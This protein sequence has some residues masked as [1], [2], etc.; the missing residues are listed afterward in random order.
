MEIVNKTWQNLEKIKAEKPL[1]HHITNMVV[2]NE[3]AN[4][5]LCLGALPV[6]AHAQEEVCEMVEHAGAL[7]LNIGTLT[8]DLVKSMVLAGCHANQLG[9]P[10]IL[11][12][13][14]VGATKLR[15]K[16][17]QTL[18]GQVKLA[19]IRGNAAEIA[20]LAG[21]EAEIKGVEAINTDA[22]LTEVCV[23]LAQDL[24]TSVAVTGPIDLVTDGKRFAEIS[25]G[26]P[27]LSTVTGTGC[28]ATSVIGAFLAVEKD[29]FLAAAGGLLTFGIAGQLAAQ[30]A[31]LKPGSF[32]VAL[33]DALANLTENDLRK[34]A[35][36]T[37]R[38]VAA[39][40]EQVV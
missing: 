4:A 36:I 15:T 31:P 2:M 5:T 12:P 32:H 37:E 8:S 17:A 24:K 40:K 18:M 11:D 20:V 25:N 16:S 33:Y 26:H 23:A 27:L 14:G 10:V 19:V 39:A 3:T 38:Q 1:I 29:P 22:N 30:A 35:K 6:M 28:M 34:Y 9:I 13:V 21:S 7:V